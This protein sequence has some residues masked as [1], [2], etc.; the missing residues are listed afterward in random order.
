M[1]ASIPVPK[2]LP[3]EAEANVDEQQHLNNSISDLED[4]DD[5]DDDDDD[6]QDEDQLHGH[7]HAHGHQHQHGHPHS[8]YDDEHRQHVRF[9]QTPAGSLILNVLES[10]PLITSIILRLL[11][12]TNV[13]AF[14]LS[15]FN[16]LAPSTASSCSVSLLPP[17]GQPDY[18]RIFSL[19]SLTTPI[20]RSSHRCLLSTSWALD[21]RRSSRPSTSSSSA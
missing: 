5:D 1:A 14:L 12:V 3:R 15:C 4:D 19:F 13:I 8:P 16:L 21:W 11:P 17:S 20:H 10:I 9:S 7:S 2:D 18:S 6:E